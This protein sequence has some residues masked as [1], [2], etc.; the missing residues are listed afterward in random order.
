MLFPHPCR[1]PTKFA[2]AI[3]GGVFLLTCSGLW[4]PA[5][6]QQAPLV[7]TDDDHF[8]LNF[9]NAEIAA[10]IATVSEIS[11][12]NFVVDPRVK[13]R[14][15]VLSSQPMS[16]DDLYE[17]F[18]AVLDVH[19][20]AAVPAG[21]IT[22]IVPQVNAKQLAGFGRDIHTREDIVTRVIQV[23]NVPAAQLVP[24]LRPL[25][26]QYGHLAA[27]PASNILIISDREAN[28]ERLAKIV[29]RIDREGNRSVERIALKYATAAD[30]VE[31]L[32][33]LKASA[34][35]AAPAAADFSVLA[36]TRTNSVVIA[37][38]PANRLRLHAIIADLDTPVEQEGGTQVIYLDYADAESLAKV[39]QSF[40]E[41]AVAR[42]GGN[43]AATRQEPVSIIAEPGAN[44]LVVNAPTEAMREIRQVIEQLDIRRGQVLVQ[45]IIAEI[46]MD[47]SRELGIDTAIF[48]DDTVV[49]GAILDASTLAAIPA[50]AANGTPLGLIEQGLNLAVG[51]LSGSTSFALLLKALSGDSH[52]NILS[53]PSLVTRDNE[54]AKIMVG[55][56]VP[57]IT[58]S[59]TSP[60][61]G[62]SSTNVNPFQTVDRQDVGLTLTI[63]PQINAG[64]TIQMDISLEV[65]SIAKGATRAVDLITNQRTLSTSV[66]IESGQILVLGGL[67]D[68]QLKESEQK[69][70]L[71]GDIP[72]L[73]ALFSSTS[74]QRTK[75]NL[76]NF[77]RPTILR[78]GAADYYTRKKYNRM[79][80]LQ[81]AKQA[82]DIP[83]L[84]D[85]RRPMLPPIERFQHTPVPP[86]SS[87]QA[88]A[89]TGT[90]IR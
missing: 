23:E 35:K 84:P 89:G 67:I 90:G 58:G 11:G 3:V 19:G 46:S 54:E 15:T 17:V 74:V 25:V 63:T 45:A 73:G 30:V 60:V 5:A 44:A 66:E 53:T 49:A 33:Q 71:L 24:I 42:Q 1:L 83:L 8:T 39:L 62:G 57:F 38:S 75:R 55:Q 64:D 65:S 10:L 36:D 77:I 13:G 32:N 88:P 47:R 68:D 27:Y 81:R 48:D 16:P 29:N 79:R 85:G 9:K 78:D 76:L 69:V 43:A 26:P 21:A 70:P 56:V 2:S 87:T 6:A 28:V 20:F 51:D 31:I 12:R 7:Q 37:G 22:K 61:T 40:A 14:V 50:L 41:K 82:T 86:Q 18:L 59:F 4:L 34:A 80:E 72:L 52:T